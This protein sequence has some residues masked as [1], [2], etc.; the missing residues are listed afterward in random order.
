MPTAAEAGSL[1]W[2][3]HPQETWCPAK[4]LTG[5][6]GSEAVR[7]EIIGSGEQRTEPVDSPKLMAMNKQNLEP[8]ADMVK[9]GD[10]HEA[11]LLHN[12]GRRF[13][14]DD[15]FTYIGPILVACNP[16]KPLPIFTPEYVQ[17]YHA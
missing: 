13:S 12:S 1:L 4:A 8:A 5:G 7:I 6:R 16:Y 14:R 10:L 2:F 11:A 3:D 15:I 9:L 17:R